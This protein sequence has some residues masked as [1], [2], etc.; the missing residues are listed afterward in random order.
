MTIKMPPLIETLTSTSRLLING[1]TYR[2]LAKAKYTMGKGGA[3]VKA[4]LEGGYAL[5]DFLEDNGTLLFVKN[6]GAI[7]PDFP[8]P[9]EFTF[10]GEEYEQVNSDTQFLEEVYFG[11]KGQYEEHLQFIDYEGKSN[12]NLFISMGLIEETGERADLAGEFVKVDDI[13]I[14]MN[15][16]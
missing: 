13:E 4:F 11:E 6:Y 16:M 7:L 15:C 10:Q 8:T 2:V 1:N 9:M 5:V 14:L 12:K 3:Y